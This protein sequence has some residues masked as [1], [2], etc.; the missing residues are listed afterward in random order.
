MV[1]KSS[2][3]KEYLIAWWILA[4]MAFFLWYRNTGIDRVVAALVFMFGILQLLNYG[5]YSGTNVNQTARAIFLT[6]WLQCLVLAVAVY[7]FLSSVNSAYM[8]TLFAL[9]ILVVYVVFFL[10]AIFY[11]LWISISHSNRSRRSA[12]KFSPRNN[13]IDTVSSWANLLGWSSVLYVIGLAL[14]IILLILYYNTSQFTIWLLAAYMVAMCVFILW[15][16]FANTGEK[17]KRST[18]V[19]SLSWTYIVLGFTFLVWMLGYFWVS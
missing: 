14:P 3:A 5:A 8:L 9:I 15:A 18:A 19:T 1:Y 11:V 13:D 10:I 12:L 2:Y 7:I 6:L 16:T 17:T 4:L